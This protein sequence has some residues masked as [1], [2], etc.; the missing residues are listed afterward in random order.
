[1]AL[2]GTGPGTGRRT[3]RYFVDA[4]VARVGK[5]WGNCGKLA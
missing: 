4:K 2:L 3:F 1:M 5:P